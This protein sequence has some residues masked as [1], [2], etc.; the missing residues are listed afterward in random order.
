[1]PVIEGTVVVNVGDLLARWT[2]DICTS[3]IHRVRP[4]QRYMDAGAVPER[5][6]I[7]FVRLLRLQIVV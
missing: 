5:F 3:T 6:S 2:N 7:P 4:L 1:V